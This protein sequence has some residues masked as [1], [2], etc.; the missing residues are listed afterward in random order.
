[1]TWDSSLN[2]GSFAVPF[3]FILPLDLP[4]SFLFTEF[5]T[6]ICLVYKLYVRLVPD[7]HKIND[8]I[9][10]K[11]VVGI[12][13]IPQMIKPIEEQK[14]V[15][16]LA[17]CCMKKGEVKLRVRW[18]NDRF[19]EGNPIQCILD[20]DNS[21]SKVIVK[22]IVVKASFVVMAS[23]STDY[24]RAFRYNL[25]KSTYF[26]EISPGSKR[27]E[28]KGRLFSFDLNDSIIKIDMSN[29]HTM[30]ENIIE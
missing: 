9:K 12:S 22:G 23:A 15:N 7:D 16:L 1:M 24:K 2:P 6:T 13:G 29:I 11:Q 14:K 5:S 27:T 3:V 30:K 25:F 8:K 10:D 18:I 17:F 21:E 20:I 26:T 4:C 19:S 28:E